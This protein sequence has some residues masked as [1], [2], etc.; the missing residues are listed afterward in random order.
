M[1]LRRALALGF[2]AV[3]LTATGYAVA[4]E[5]AVARQNAIVLRRLLFGHFDRE[6][7][8]VP[9]HGRTSTNVDRNSVVMFVFSG[10]VA[11]GPN[12][13]ATLPLTLEE[14]NE[15][16]RLIAEDPNFDPEEFGYEPG[17]T[18]RRKSTDRSAFYIAT[19]SVTT[20]SIR[21]ASP[22]GSGETLAP[23]HFFK[24]VR[25]GGRGA[26]AANRIIFNPRYKL[27]TTNRPGDIEH[28]PEGLDANT[29]YTITLDGGPS[30]QDPFNV[31]RNLDGLG[32]AAGFQTTFQTSGRYVQDY[33][34]PQVRGTSPGG[35]N[36]PSDDD[37]ELAFSEPMDLATFITPKF[38]G[39][40]QW[41]VVARYSGHQMNGA[42][43]IGRN[44]ITSVRTKPQTAGNVVQIRPL[45]GFGKGPF[46]IEVIVRTSVTDLSG[47]SIIRQ[48]QFTFQTEN[49][50]DADQAGS[51][52]E[53]FTDTSKRDA[54]FTLADVTG[55]NT[56]ADW[57][58]P[59]APGLLRT[60]VQERDSDA[61]GPNINSQTNVW[62][63]APIQFQHLYPNADMGN[64][65][66]T[67]AGFSWRL[68]VLYAYTYPSTSVQL[69]HATDLIA[70]GG[71]AGAP[72]AANYRDTPALTFGPS[73]YTTGTTV[74]GSYVRGPV[75][76]SNFNY[77]GQHSVIL[78]INHGGGPSTTEEWWAIDS[79]YAL[80]VL[81]V[82]IP[83]IPTTL[84]RP[85]YLATRFH[86]LTPGAEARSLFYDI[87]RSDARILPAQLVPT[88]QPQG[89]SLTL[90]WQGAKGDTSNPNLIDMNT[91]TAWNP[92]IRQFA[93]YRYLR[94]HATLRNNVGAG[95][96][97]SLD[98]LTIPYVYR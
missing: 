25:P 7:R 61:N 89:T 1:T 12:I 23:G 50:P 41:T 59:A 32:L 43:L 21:I 6:G 10:P 11:S 79:V 2:A 56:L 33:T 64:R 91:L 52:E 36:V 75:F 71:F 83:S 72:S 60:T 34:R 29:Q 70:A 26:V 9:T 47:N 51:I 65:A 38:Q 24:V 35:T 98:R 16:E 27:S 13:R 74:A 20:N 42:T 3:A 14:Q 97:P 49:D 55:D 93:N 53:T 76:T 77:D 5:L 17:V 22:T 68:G 4:H 40:D 18:P 62:Y 30:P 31:V 15:F 19:G 44:L 92:D 69:G 63:R 96:S 28:N 87:T 45:Q 58:S 82:S 39:D 94:F 84:A 80:N 81:A 73:N 78:E 46:E 66:R 37:I 48:I 57:A 95:T 8:F 67:I 85:W 90:L 88:T 86:Y 54:Q